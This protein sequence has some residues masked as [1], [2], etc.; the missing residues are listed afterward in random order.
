MNQ[1]RDNNSQLSAQEI[2]AIKVTQ[3]IIKRMAEN[4]QKMK[5]CFLAM[6]ALFYAILG[7]DIAE[8]N[9]KMYGAFL[10]PTVAFWVMDAKYLQIERQFR[11]HHK[12]IV[13]GT[14][15]T[16]ATWDFSPARY[17]VKNLFFTMIS[18]SA[19]IYP[20]MAAMALVFLLIA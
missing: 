18:F 6:C 5:T 13:Y 12:A 2:E 17:R 11:E 20:A 8:F 16:L 19:W 15:P 7:K 9:L 10:F 1:I 3:D 4:S 14:I